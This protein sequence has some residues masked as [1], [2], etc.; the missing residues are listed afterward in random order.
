MLTDLGDM[1]CNGMGVEQDLTAAR[2]Y[3]EKAAEHGHAGALRNL[4]ALYAAGAAGM[5]KDL[6]KAMEFY[7]QVRLT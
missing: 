2:A 1:Y 7:Q 5:E 6:E 4:G 3:Y